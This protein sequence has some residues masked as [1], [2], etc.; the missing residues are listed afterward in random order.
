MFFLNTVLEIIFLIFSQ[1]YLSYE[2]FWIDSFVLDF[3]YA[4]CF[5][6][7]GDQSF[8][9]LRLLCKVQLGILQFVASLF[10]A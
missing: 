4:G 1:I 2:K 3:L 8:D 5:F 7:K 10:F 6:L 9:P